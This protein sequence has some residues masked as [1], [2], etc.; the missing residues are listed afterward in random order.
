VGSANK[1]K[2]LAIWGTAALL[3]GWIALSLFHPEAAA[4]PAEAVLENVQAA[5][6]PPPAPATAPTIAMRLGPPPAPGSEPTEAVQDP[7]P[8]WP[9]DVSFSPETA[10]SAPSVQSENESVDFS[11]SGENGGDA[12]SDDGDAGSGESGGKVSA[13]QTAAL[14]IS[15]PAQGGGSSLGFFSPDEQTIRLPQ[16]ALSQGAKLMSP[17]ISSMEPIGML[18]NADGSKPQVKIVPDEPPRRRLTDQPRPSG[19]SPP[20][21]TDPNSSGP[22]S[23]SVMVGSYREADNAERV[24]QK[25]AEADLPVVVLTVTTGNTVWHRVISGN[26][27]K[28]SDAEA[29]GRE[30]VQRK[31]VDD[32]FVF[33][34]TM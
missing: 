21:L 22:M 24:R 8:P 5:A 34:R 19:A 15:E 25:M 10:E 18:A 3:I 31:I 6:A 33:S 16:G 1:I 14:S 9:A 32:A 23:Y 12:G 20:P 13:I 2:A 11:G 28:L 17:G 7:S 29:Y 4:P 30:L 27:E 26:F